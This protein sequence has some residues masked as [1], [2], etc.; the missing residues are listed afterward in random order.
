MERIVKNIFLIKKVLG[1]ISK[2]KKNP[3]INQQIFV[4]RKLSSLRRVQNFSKDNETSLLVFFERECI[5]Q[6]ALA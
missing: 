3:K 1:C 6:P 5:S 2:L 4:F